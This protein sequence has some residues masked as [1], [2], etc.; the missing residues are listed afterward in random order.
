MQVIKLPKF[1]FQITFQLIV[2]I[3]AVMFIF[4][5]VPL[6]YCITAIPLVL[7]LIF[8]TIYSS[9]LMKSVELA[10]KTPMQCWIAEVLEPR[11][12]M[13]DPRKLKHLVMTEEELKNEEINLN[14]YRR[15]V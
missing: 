1:T 7:L 8:I 11:Y 3:S 10:N 6:F 9:L 2:T 12:F 4:V 15:K 13:E 14:S 5:G